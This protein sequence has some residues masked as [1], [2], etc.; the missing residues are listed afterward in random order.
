MLRSL[1]CKGPNSLLEIISQI[2]QDIF[3]ARRGSKK[4]PVALSETLTTLTVHE[5]VTRVLQSYLGLDSKPYQN[6]G[7]SV[8]HLRDS[9]S[10]AHREYN[11]D[12]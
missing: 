9:K 4:N 3:Y 2:F 7:L 1:Q 6:E 11:S 12:I 10:K 5:F 8:I